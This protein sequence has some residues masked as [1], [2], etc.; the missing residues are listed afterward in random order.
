MGVV[1]M[2]RDCVREAPPVYLRPNERVASIR[3][4]YH[5]RRKGGKLWGYIVEDKH[6]EVCICSQKLELIKRH[7]N[8]M[9]DCKPDQ[10]SLTGLYEIIS[11]IT[12]NPRSRTGG[13]TKHRWFV[14][15]Y[16]LDELARA[17]EIAR[18]K[19][20]KQNVVLGSAPIVETML[21]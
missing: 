18:A 10:V 12:D 19:G 1:H 9:V 8:Q 20:F 17:F 11:V 13:A 16:T 5:V 3:P 4:D 6:H 21:E 2:K 14:H 15:K 7:I